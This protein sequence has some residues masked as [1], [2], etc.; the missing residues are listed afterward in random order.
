MFWIA[1]AKIVVGNQA[2]ADLMPSWRLVIGIQ[3]MT[4]AIQF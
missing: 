4:E 3:P 1:E 2:Y